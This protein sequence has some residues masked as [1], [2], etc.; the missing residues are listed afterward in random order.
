MSDKANAKL[1]RPPPSN[2]EQ[3]ARD[4]NA[5]TEPVLRWVYQLGYFVFCATLVLMLVITAIWGFCH[6]Y[7]D[8]TVFLHYSVIPFGALG[9]PRVVTWFLKIAGAKVAQ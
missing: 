6:R 7:P 2:G 5:P 1:Q 4:Q 8:Y 9:G 3:E